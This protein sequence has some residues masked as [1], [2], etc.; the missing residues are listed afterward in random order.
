MKLTNVTKAAIINGFTLLFLSLGEFLQLI[1]FELILSYQWHKALHIMGVVIL[2]GNMIVGPIWFLYAYY[3]KDRTLL[4]FANRLL[5]LTDLYLTI[6]G[7]AL[8]VING[9]FLASVFGG[10]R[11]VPWLF[12]SMMWLYVM[13]A[14]SVPLIYLQERLYSAIDKEPPND[15]EITKL[16]FRWGIL[17]SAITIPPTVIFCLMIFK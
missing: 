7:I 6:P 15:V 8:T 16:L 17:G 11:H 5:Q 1:R 9:L 3:S 12:Q 13:W 14:L 10:T 2:M 4:L